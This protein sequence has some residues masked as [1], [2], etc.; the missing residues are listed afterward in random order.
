MASSAGHTC[1]RVL[2]QELELLIWAPS[3]RKGFPSTSKENLPSFFAMRGISCANSKLG[4]M[5]SNNRHFHPWFMLKVF[6]G[7][8][9]FG[10]TVRPQLYYGLWLGAILPFW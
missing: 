8:Q 6:S 5:P 10:L 4:I 1:G 2:A 3:I 9:C 7:K